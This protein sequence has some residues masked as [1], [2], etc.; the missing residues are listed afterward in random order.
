MI[1]VL[2]SNTPFFAI[3]LLPLITPYSGIVPLKINSAAVLLSSP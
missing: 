3:M 2:K 1:N